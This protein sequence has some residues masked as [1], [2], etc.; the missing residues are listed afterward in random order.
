MEFVPFRLSVANRPVSDVTVAARNDVW[1]VSMGGLLHF[2]RSSWTA[3]RGP[4]W[5]S[6]AMAAGLP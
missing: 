3:S 2:D 5:L 6:H 4:R 1:A